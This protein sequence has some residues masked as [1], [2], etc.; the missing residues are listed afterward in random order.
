[1]L[2]EKNPE[3]WAFAAVW[4]REINIYAWGGEGVG[5]TS[6]CKYLMCKDVERGNNVQSPSMLSL[7]SIS[8]RFDSEN[9]L[10]EYVSCKTLL[11]DDIHDPCLTQSGYSVLRMLIDVRHEANRRTLVTTNKNPV[12]MMSHL[13][14][15]CGDGFGIQFMRR[16]SPV[17]ELAMAGTSYRKTINENVLSTLT[18]EDAQ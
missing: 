7:Q 8:K 11:L 9:H 5:K 4:K 10:Y 17:K 13:N 16:L 3:A 18:K 1:M 15:I 6:L 12:D 14:G 2:I